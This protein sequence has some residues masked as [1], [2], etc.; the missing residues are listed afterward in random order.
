MSGL[1]WLERERECVCECVEIEVRVTS[2]VRAGMA[3]DERRQSVCVCLRE[4]N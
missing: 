3:G 2:G 4:R 1:V